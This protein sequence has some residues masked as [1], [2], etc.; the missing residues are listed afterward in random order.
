MTLPQGWKEDTLGSLCSI[1]IGGTP[2]RNRSEY[3]DLAG[4][5]DNF[6]VAISDMDCPIITD[7]AEK[8]T[9]QGIKSSNVKQLRRGTVLLSFKLSIGRVAVAG[10]DLFTNEAI[11][12]LESGAID[13]GFLVYGLQS[14]NLLEGV[15][16]AI[17]GATL[18]KEKLAKLRCTYP[19]DRAEQAKIATVL[20]TIDKAI[21]QTE[22]LI[23]KQQRIKAGLMQD[24]LTRGIDEH[25]NLRSEATH[26]FKD[27]FIGRIPVE[28]SATPIGSLADHV[29]SGS[30]GWAR[31]YSVEGA[32][33]LRVGNLSRDHI[34]MRFD[35]EAYVSP[36]GNS[37]GRRTSLLEGDLLISITADLGMIGV[38]PSNFGEAYINQHLALIRFGK[39][40]V[41]SRFL[42]YWLLSY[43]AQ[44]QFQSL[45]ESGA[46]AGLNLP[47]I[48]RVIVP[49]TTMLDEQQR[50]AAILD[51]HAQALRKRHDALG[52]LRRLKSALMQDLLTGKVPVTPLL[53][54]E[55]VG[56]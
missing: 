3:W 17:K 30:R 31:Y 53:E 34:D 32:R 36:P 19:E 41:C 16:Q 42:G 39:V 35:D 56:A 50:I 55:E 38:V 14:W 40:G 48:E 37:E 15:D 20:S 13:P 1:K 23:A 44:Q 18:N 6:W 51:G 25:G 33:F 4:T 29:T 7:T 10:V 26:E 21:A 11:A 28:W 22:A 24:L 5:T 46:K 43:R 45:N 12:G 47:T 27:S 49:T 54:A 2:S 8:I 52:K 9:E